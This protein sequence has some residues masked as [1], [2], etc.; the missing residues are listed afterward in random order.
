MIRFSCKNCGQKL[1]V[2]DKHYGRQVKC[3]KCGEVVVVPANLDKI[4]FHCKSCDQKISVPQ[5]HAGK[6]GKCPKCQNAVVIPIGKAVP[7]ASPRQGN[8]IPPR[9]QQNQY[10]A[11]SEETQESEGVN[12]RLILMISG[13]AIVAVF[14]LIIL[15]V[16]LRSSN[17]EPDISRNQEV[18]V[19]R[20][21]QLQS[22]T[23][24]STP[25]EF[26]SP[27][28]K[29]Y[30]QTKIAFTLIRGSNSDIYVMNAD[31]SE[32]KR[33]TNNSGLLD[34]IPAFSWSPDGKKITF[35]SGSVDGNSG[36]VENQV[37]NV[38]NADGSEL[39]NITNNPA[40]NYGRRPSW[41]PDGQKIALGLSRTEGN[42]GNY[43]VRDG[44]I[45]VMN[46][47]G[48]QMKN[49]TNSIA[50]DMLPSWSPDGKKIV[51]LSGSGGNN[52]IYFMNADGSEQ[53]NLTNGFLVVPEGLSWSP[54]GKKIAFLSG[55]GGNNEI[56]VMNAD[57][58]ELKN[59][60]NYPTLYMDISWS[61]DGKKLAFSSNRD[62]NSE[63]YVVNVDGSEQRNLTNN[64]LSDQF[65]S[66]SPDGKKIAFATNRDRNYE[67]YVMN[68]DGSELKN[69]TN[70]LLAETN[71]SWSP[72]MVSEVIDKDLQPQ[73]VTS[74]KLQLNKR[75]NVNIQ[76]NSSKT[77]LGFAKQAEGRPGL[78]ESAIEAFYNN[79]GVYPGT[80]DDLLTCPKGY[81][82]K[83]AGPYLQPSSLKDPWGNKYI[84][85]PNSLNPAGYDLISSTAKDISQKIITIITI[86]LL[87]LYF[88]LIVSMWIVFNKANQPGWAILIPFY[89]AWILA[90]VGEKPG[91][92]GLIMIFCVVI[93]Y[94]GPLIS[95]V[96]HI[97]ISIGVART[98]GHGV[99]LGLGLCFLPFIFYPILSFSSN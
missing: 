29:L 95:L 12:V 84:Y 11:E 3:P 50:F 26:S 99:I 17:K 71:P 98:F 73:P 40:L 38:M 66:W 35:L 44:E 51:F 60:T 67:I 79:C 28:E 24:V 97:I 96:L 90:R 47:D 4:T 89:N 18:A 58:S 13:A 83:W 59:L 5:I 21:S 32:P 23:A 64:H 65:P 61:P 52:G 70:S 72:F 87:L 37:I 15:A 62:G 8:S 69:L 46:A 75:A 34:V 9:T 2:D 30:K 78:I 7:A 14:G 68:A 76:A 43:V 39:K 81:E 85:K 45:Y 54:D 55:S 93:P 91:W 27:E 86:V 6:K 36:R 56:Y 31:G 16:V 53:R 22:I 63:I 10:P 49:L 1:N 94:I 41:S 57:G 88:L 25:Q 82:D 33:L 77:A 74:D 19:D 92:M 80:L 48:S 42:T 20:D